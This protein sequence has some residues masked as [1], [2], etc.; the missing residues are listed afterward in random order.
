MGSGLDDRLA[1]FAPG[2]ETTGQRKRLGIAQ[3]FGRRNG[4]AR[5]HTAGADHDQGLIFIARHLGQATGQ[6]GQGNVA[7]SRQ[8]TTSFLKGLS[9]L[10]EAWGGAL[11]IRGRRGH[12][13]AADDPLR[14]R[15]TATPPPKTGEERLKETRHGP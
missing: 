14:R 1:G 10:R 8:V 2:L 7:R 6:V 13:T 15:M 9:S 11:V 3:F 4:A 5:A 12:G